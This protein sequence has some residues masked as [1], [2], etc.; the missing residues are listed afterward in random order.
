MDETTAID[1]RHLTKTYKI[2][3]KPL[4]RIKEAMNPFHRRYSTDFA[5]LTDVSFT[6]RR[7]ETLGII[8][9]NGAGKS[10]L[11]KIITGV[12]TPSGGE[13]R[14]QGR[15][16]SLLELGA[17]FNPEMSGMENIYLNGTIMGCNRDEMERR[18]PEI[19]A[20]ADIGDFLYQPVKTYSSGMFARLAFAVNSNVSPDILIVDEALAVGDVFFQNKCFRKL[21]ALREQGTTILFVSHDIGSV[22]QLCTHVLWLEHGHVVMD[23]DP[24]TVCGQYFNAEIAA[25][26]ET[27]KEPSPA[28]AQPQASLQAASAEGARKIHPLPVKEGDILS[29]RARILSFE[30]RGADGRPTAV[31]M[32]GQTYS[33]HVLVEAHD[34]IPQCILGITFSNPKGIDIIGT[35]TFSVSKGENFSLHKGEYLDVVFTYRM[36]A[37]LPGPY[38]WDTALSEGTQVTHCVLTWLHGVSRT[39]VLNDASNRLGLVDV[40]ASL[41]LETIGRE[42]IELS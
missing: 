24:E 11:L 5:A 9:K 18:V 13:A 37:I 41:S 26:N 25:R 10:T 36:P 40:D 2:F 4:D 16:A 33:V 12:L 38:V 23:G 29:A 15:I 3:A 28:A 7:G 27:V 39:E 20:F 32:A 19:I 21:E 1:V 17:G 42:Q 35:N 6:V 31:M 22:K 30:I 34:D 8:G 14:A